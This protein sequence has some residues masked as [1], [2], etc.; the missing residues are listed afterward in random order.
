VLL[1]IEIE[2]SILKFIRKQKRFQIAK[3]TMDNMKN[4]GGI[5]IPKFKLYYRTILTKTAWYWHK[6]SRHVDQWNRIEHTSDF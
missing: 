4:A 6:N 2:K 5:P 3:T 1:L